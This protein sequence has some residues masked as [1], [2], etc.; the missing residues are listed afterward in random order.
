VKKHSRRQTAKLKVRL[1][2]PI[3]KEIKDSV[4][5]NALAELGPFDPVMSLINNN[6]TTILASAK[7]HWYFGEWQWLTNINLELF[8]DHPDLAKLALLKASGFQ[9]LGDMQSC[10]TFLRVAKSKGCDDF[11]I[12]KILLAGVHNS[13][14]RISALKHD[15]P[16]MQ[17]HFSQAVDAGDRER[18]TKLAI[19]ARTVKELADLGLLTKAETVLDSQV[20]LFA[21]TKHIAKQQDA[22]LN[23][24]RKQQQELKIAT[25][26][27]RP[28]DGAAPGK[29]VILIASM[30][31]SGSTWLFN[32]AI[33]LLKLAGKDVY[34]SWVDDYDVS[35]SAKIHLI[36]AHDPVP[37]LSEKA[38]HIISTRRDIR[39]VAASLTR[40]KWNKSGD[41]FLNQLNRMVNTVHQFWFERSDLEIEYNQIIEEPEIAI[42]AISHSLNVPV[43]AKTAIQISI[44][45]DNLKAPKTYDLKTQLHPHHRAMKKV[46]YSEVLNET[47][48]NDINCA[49]DEWLDLF[50]Y[51]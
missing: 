22:L 8:I 19:K 20:N 11:S 13:L 21:K 41:D 37:V 3:R 32:C 49:F 5:D 6:N 4:V 30:P 44:E 17:A 31:R 27:N 46:H 26:A 18:D 2:Q 50:G 40:M 10:E 23:L 9:Q 47:L 29:Q 35:N 45:L 15:H 48:V 7:A 14:G 43:T 12:A 1:K 25:K 24:I 34:S 28:I 36:K 16:Q 33:K 39:D 51:K 38:D 42:E